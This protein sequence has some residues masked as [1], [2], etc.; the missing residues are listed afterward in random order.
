[1]VLSKKYGGVA[2]SQFTGVAGRSRERTG[3][4]VGPALASQDVC[5][6][7]ATEEAADTAMPDKTREDIIATCIQ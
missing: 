3:R 2:L 7:E 6:A 4:K 5:G 1:V